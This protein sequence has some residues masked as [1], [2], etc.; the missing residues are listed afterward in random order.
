MRSNLKVNQ[1]ASTIMALRGER[2]S[3]LLALL[4]VIVLLILVASSTLLNL[5][6]I[7]ALA[8]TTQQEVKSIT[9]LHTLVKKDTE[10]GKKT[11]LSDLALF[12]NAQTEIG[13]VTNSNYNLLGIEYSDSDPTHAKAII[14]SGSGDDQIYTVGDKLSQNT[15]IDSITP[16]SVI[17]M[18]N[19]VKEKLSLSW[20]GNSLI[21]DQ[22]QSVNLQ[23]NIVVRPNSP[24]MNLSPG[25]MLYN[26]QKLKQENL[27]NDR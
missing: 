26:L 21:S 6:G 3:Y 8:V 10:T 16:N 9:Q 24:F 13:A 17:L 25:T 7:A 4:A 20:E 27:L 15:V 22:P 14:N 18:R 12:G 2:W 1:M 23:N 11:K 5:Y 19:G